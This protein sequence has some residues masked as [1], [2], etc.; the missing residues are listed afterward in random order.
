MVSLLK[1]IFIRKVVVEFKPWEYFSEDG[2]VY[3]NG[4]LLLVDGKEIGQVGHDPV[5]TVH[6]VLTELGYKVEIKQSYEQHSI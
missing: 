1:K 6:S 4:V 3:I 5:S 2:R